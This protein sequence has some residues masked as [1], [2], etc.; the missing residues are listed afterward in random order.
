MAEGEDGFTEPGGSART[1]RRPRWPFIAA[2][3]AAVVVALAVAI[4]FWRIPSYRPELQPREQLGVD[5]SNHQGDI[6]WNRVRAD[7]IDFA[8]LK[9]TE[10]GDYVDDRFAANWAATT[11]A[12][13]R[14]GAYHFFTLCRPG[15]DQAD[16]F[17]HVVPHDASAL[18]PAVDLEYVG[19]CAARPA[20]ADLLR[21]LRTFIDRVESAT[22]QEAVLYVLDDID[23]DYQI[24][25]TIDR[26]VWIRHLFTRP[27]TDTWLIWQANFNANV[28]GI[29][30]PA[31]LDVM[32]ANPT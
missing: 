10:G 20:R 5:V 1:R 30:G 28:A 17:L 9:A 16:N 14:H 26:P 3:V 32:K 7:G 21:E 24:T 31:D 13:V 2:G 8:Y 6:D 12:G 18:P 25:Q 19:N 22:G 11:T 27:A 29:D 15:T 4:W 23:A